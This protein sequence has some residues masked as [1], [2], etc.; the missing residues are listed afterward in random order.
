[1]ANESLDA[2]ALDAKALDA[3]ALDAKAKVLD[4]KAKALDAKAEALDAKAEA[5]GKR[6]T[7]SHGRGRVDKGG[8][9]RGR[10]R[11]DR[12]SRMRFNVGGCCSAQVLRP[13][14]RHIGCVYTHVSLPRLSTRGGQLHGRTL[15]HKGG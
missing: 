2:K 7:R 3:K 5:L 1:M 12:D 4:A 8:T 14:S 13:G 11:L 9:R 10:Q 6:K 15:W